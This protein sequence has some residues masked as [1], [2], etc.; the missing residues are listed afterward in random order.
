MLGPS[1]PEPKNQ[2]ED[3]ESKLPE[4]SCGIYDPNCD[5]NM[6]PGISFTRGGA[7][8]GFQRNPDGT[9]CILIGPFMSVPLVSPTVNMGGL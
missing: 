6:Q 7:G 4:G 9:Y 8:I 1:K 2:C 3:D 5:N